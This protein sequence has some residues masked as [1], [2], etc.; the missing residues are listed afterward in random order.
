MDFGIDLGTWLKVPISSYFHDGHVEDLKI[1]FPQYDIPYIH[2]SFPFLKY[3]LI[4]AIL[5][6]NISINKNTIPILNRGGRNSHSNFMFNHFEL[7]LGTPFFTKIG[8]MAK[9]PE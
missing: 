1:L 8:K 5:S 7:K 2:P 9:L 6:Y 4:E 3:G